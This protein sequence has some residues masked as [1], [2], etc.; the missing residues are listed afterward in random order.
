[1]S[2]YDQILNG[3]PTNAHLNFKNGEYFVMGKTESYIVL[4]LS[5]TYHYPVYC[6]DSVTTETD[7]F[8]RPFW[9]TVKKCI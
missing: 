4:L 3:N 2:Y 5:N 6:I 1:M 8:V 7:I 9:N